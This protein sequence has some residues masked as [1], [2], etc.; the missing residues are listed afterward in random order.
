MLSLNT[1]IE[2]ATRLGDYMLSAREEWLEAQEKAVYANTWFTPGDISNAINSIAT[3]YLQ[4]EKLEAWAAKYRQADRA[5]TVGIVMAGN[6]PLVGFHDFLC[7]FISGHKMLLKLSSKDN[8]LLPHL[9]KQLA[10][11]EPSTKDFIGVSEILKG[12]DAYI[13]TGSNNTARYFEQYFGKYPH[14]I[15]KNR[16]SVAI[17]EGTETHQE[18]LALG[19]DVFSYFGLGCRNV[20]QVCVPRGY[21]FTNL[22]ST[23]E[24]FEDV[25]N[26]HKYKN[27]YDYYLAI[28]LLNKVPYLT[29]GSV[30]MI[31]N[32]MPFSPVAVLHYRYYDDRSALES[33]LKSSREIQC[34]VGKGAIPFGSAQ[35][36]SLS[37]FAD[38]LDTM[39]FLTGL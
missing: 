11:W 4:K 31:E 26:H 34:V 38:G 25:A 29:N 30:L 18:L 8:V 1:R 17:L 22:L 2:L 9:I 39:Q 19:K 3:Q 37:D 33:E 7:A 28:Y 6:I 16:T 35:T 27:N 12:C 14:I 20:S 24:H 23:F 5:V 13:A 32:A 36:P 10:D 21:D 15:R